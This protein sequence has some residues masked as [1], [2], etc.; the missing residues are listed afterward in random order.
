MARIVDHTQR[1]IAVGRTPSGRVISSS[2]RPLPDNTQ[3]SQQTNVHAPGWIRTH[4]PSRRAATD[5]RPRPL[6]HWD[7]RIFLKIKIQF[8]TDATLRRQ[9]RRTRRFE[10]TWFVHLFININQ[11]DALNFI[12]SLF[13]AST[14]FEH[15]YSSSGGQIVL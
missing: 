7:R 3:Q 11:L 14:C 4:N 13:Q 12:L 15:M 1:G 2:Q 10:E 8:F 9:G 6:G 5:P